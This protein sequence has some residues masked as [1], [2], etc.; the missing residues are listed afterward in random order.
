VHAHWVQV[1]YGA[2]DDDIVLDI[3]H[4][5]QLVFLPAKNRFLNHDLAGEAGVQALFDDDFKLLHVV[6][7]AAARAPKGE[8]WPYY[9][10]KPYSGCCIPR[11]LQSVGKKACRDLEAD[12]CHGL[13]EELAAF[14][15]FNDIHIGAYKLNPIGVKHTLPG[16]GHGGVQPCLAAKS[17]QHGVGPLPLHNGCHNFW[18]NR[19]NIGAV[20]C[21]RVCHYGGGVGVDQHNLVAL[22]LEG[23]AGLGA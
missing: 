12:F 19:F 16:A 7:N 23:L 8:A 3:A 21:L 9:Y 2:D 4:H 1:F 5:L 22:L 13:P 20:G 18:R 15:L 10:G 14:S 17:G 11:L 6:G